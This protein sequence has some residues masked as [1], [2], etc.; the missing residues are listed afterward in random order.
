MKYK[1]LTLIITFLLAIQ[2]YGQQFPVYTQYWTNKFLLNPAVAGHEGYTSVNLTARK[3]WAGMQDAPGTV[4]ISAQTRV[5]KNS[6]II[7]KRSVRNRRKMMSKSGRVGYG[8]YLF[9][10][11]LG[12]INKLGFQGTYSYHLTLKRAQLS[13]GGSLVGLQYNIDK[14]AIILEESAD[15]LILST[16]SKAYLIDGNFGTYFSNK[17][18]YAG[19]AV[20]NMFESY[21]KLNNREGSK[22][23]MQRQY[24]INSGYRFDVYDFVYL[25]PSFNFKFS[26]NVVSQIDLNL[27]AY[28]KEDYWGGLGYRSGSSSKISSETLGG[29][30]SSILIFGGAR[31]DK[32]FFGYSFDYTLSS[33]QKRTYGSHEV[34]IAVRFGDN[35]RRYRWLNRY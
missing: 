25:E 34:M 15:N 3:Q 5:L 7:K 2:V 19:I 9:D 16:A 14:S 18:L 20:Q 8:A 31:I 26:E 13:F 24:L 12:A 10:D 4:A 23:K 11:N 21:F 35:A 28:F 29:R 17:N 32:F 33:I 6:H 30:G 22:I 27:S 1:I